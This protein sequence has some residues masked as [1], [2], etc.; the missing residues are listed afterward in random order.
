MM[1][2]AACKGFTHSASKSVFVYSEECQSTAAIYWQWRANSRSTGQTKMYCSTGLIQKP[3]DEQLNV[4][5]EA[6][7]YLGDY[8]PSL[9]YTENASLP[10]PSSEVVSNYVRKQPYHSV[11]KLFWCKPETRNE[12]VWVTAFYIGNNKIMTAAHAFDGVEGYA[13][14]N[15]C[16]CDD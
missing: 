13:G 11:G 12:I 7:K 2:E 10:K 9:N 5:Q 6:K 1:L 14:I 16:A 4:F 15:L 8:T 3:V